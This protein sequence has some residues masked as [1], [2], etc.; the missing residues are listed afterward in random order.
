MPFTTSM[1]ERER[2]YFFI[3]SRTAPENIKITSRAK[4][5]NRILLIVQSILF[6]L[7]QIATRLL[8]TIVIIIQYFQRELLCTYHIYV[9]ICICYELNYLSALLVFII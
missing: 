1:E 4:Q 6:E 8:C 7:W 2:R 5:Q 9:K 3:L